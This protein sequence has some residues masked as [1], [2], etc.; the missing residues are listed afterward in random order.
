M[1]IKNVHLNHLRNDEHFNFMQVFLALIVEF[2]AAKLK[3]EPQ[4]AALIA[5]YEKE[6]KALKKITKSAITEQIK[7]ADIARDNSFLGFTGTVE[8]AKNHFSSAV[9]DAAIRV[10]IANR[11]YGDVTVKSYAEETS[12]L[13]NLC[14]DLKTTY[15]EDL[16]TLNLV[17]WVKEIERLN[18]AV[19]DLQNSRL[20][21]SAGKT[22]LAMKQVRDEVDEAY[23][24][25][26]AMVSAQA[27]VATMGTDT[28]AVAM[29]E[30]F[31]KLL[32]IQIDKTNNALA[33]RRGRAKAKKEEEE[34][35]A[36]QQ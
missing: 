14:Q 11:N 20:H 19:A 32:N 3:V 10:S 4:N 27:L 17:Q 5:V 2:G 21:E 31:E 13:Y 16:I 36:E 9:R 35:S 18:K 7:E 12:L 25:L 28:E 22:S 26:I 6:D 23:N 29:Y 30:E 33:T 24:A 8:S 1:T 15:A 34:E